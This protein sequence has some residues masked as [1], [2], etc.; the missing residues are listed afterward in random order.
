MRDAPASARIYAWFGPLTWEDLCVLGILRMLIPR[1]PNRSLATAVHINNAAYLTGPCTMRD[2][3]LRGLRMNA[4][5]SCLTI[6]L[7]CGFT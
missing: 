6:V 3:S 5:Y 7:Y 4:L 2:C 1:E